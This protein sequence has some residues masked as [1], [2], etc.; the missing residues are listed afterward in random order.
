MDK[1]GARSHD[2]PGA[3]LSSSAASLSRSV[4]PT[5]EVPSVPPLM[6][7][8]RAMRPAAA[9]GGDGV[10]GEV[11]PLR[12][13]T[14]S[15][16]M[17]ASQSSHHLSV[18]RAAGERP[19]TSALGREVKT[20]RSPESLTVVRIDDR[21]S[22]SHQSTPKISIT[23]LQDEVPSQSSGESSH[24]SSL[25]RTPNTTS[26]NRPSGVYVSSSNLQVPV[27]S[28]GMPNSMVPK[29]VIATAPG[30]NEH[31][32]DGTAH[33]W[34][35]GHHV[36]QPPQLTTLSPSLSFVSSVMS[37]DLDI[38]VPEVSATLLRSA[39][40]TLCAA[41]IA[42]TSPQKASSVE[43]RHRSLSSVKHA[44]CSIR[45]RI[46]DAVMVLMRLWTLIT[47]PMYSAW[48]YQF[49]STPMVVLGYVHDAAVLLNVVLMSRRS[50]LN[51]YGEEIADP[52]RIRSHYMRSAGGYW[53]LLGVIPFDLV[54]LLM[55]HLMYND[56]GCHSDAIAAASYT[57]FVTQCVGAFCSTFLF[58]R[59]QCCNADVGVHACAA[60]RCDSGASLCT[61][62]WAI[63]RWTRYCT[64][65]HAFRLFSDY[66]LPNV[67]PSFTRL[68]KNL[69]YFVL[70][71]HIDTC[72]FQLLCC[73][74]NSADAWCVADGHV[75]CTRRADAWTGSMPMDWFGR[76]TMWP[77]AM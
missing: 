20:L 18:G 65:V 5:Q 32:S 53:E 45:W 60:R 21:A 26:L 47:V 33:E 43:H 34:D 9:V 58:A 40:Q 27:Q 24:T 17:S 31:I 51:E 52:A 63:L 72:L 16:P 38:H 54:P 11:R 42:C 61:K 3:P 2:G 67:H 28:Y 36:G 35:H 23:S 1:Q 55:G 71:A 46:W 8:P 70:A 10:F 68:V 12:S 64:L 22:G 66:D 7:L 48:L 13:R 49:S 30:D 62:M 56:F 69:L 50:F 74:E 25:A 41:P 59:A 19:R 76:Q 6:S 15:S 77:L 4:L 29:L 73:F 14:H 44:R 37:H 39:K 57:S 75:W